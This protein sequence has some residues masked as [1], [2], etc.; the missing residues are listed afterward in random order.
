MIDNDTAVNKFFKVHKIG[1]GYFIRLDPKLIDNITDPFTE[2]KS[3]DGG[4][5]LRRAGRKGEEL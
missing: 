3:S 1:D 4:I 2:E 5:L